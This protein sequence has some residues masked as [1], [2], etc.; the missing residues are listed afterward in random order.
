MDE[1]TKNDRH[2][3]FSE[4]KKTLVGC[5]ETLGRVAWDWGNALKQV[6]EHRLRFSRMKGSMRSW[7]TLRRA[8]SMQASTS[9][10]SS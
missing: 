4:C 7:L 1:L 5:D 10:S 8:Y 6:Q 2:H 3:L 9:S